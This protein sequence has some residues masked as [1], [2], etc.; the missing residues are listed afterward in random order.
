[1]K[2]HPIIFTED[3]TLKILSGEKTQTRRLIKSPAKPPVNVGD[4]LWV[5]ETFL[6]FRIGHYVYHADYT[7][8]GLGELKRDGYKWVSPIFMPRLVSRITLLVTGVDIARLQDISDEDAI[9]EGIDCTPTMS[10]GCTPIQKFHALW[11]S[12]YGEESWDL[13]PLVRKIKF[14]MIK[15]V[16]SL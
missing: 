1:M 9:A 2:E 7:E 16:N 12:I 13:N 15:N 4:Y 14:E 10:D 5:R 3:L 8:K 11:L 6:E